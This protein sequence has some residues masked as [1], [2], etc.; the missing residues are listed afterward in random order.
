MTAFSEEQDV[1]LSK[2]LEAAFAFFTFFFAAMVFSFRP[3]DRHGHKGDSSQRGS[4]HSFAQE[5]N[6]LQRFQRQ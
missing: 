3:I 6:S 5:T 1:A 2:V 4:N